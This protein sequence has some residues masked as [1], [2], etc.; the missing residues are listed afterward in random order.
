M[1]PMGALTAISRDIAVHIDLCGERVAGIQRRFE[2]HTLMPSEAKQELAEAEAALAA[3][4]AAFGIVE[5]HTLDACESELQASIADLHAAL[6]P[7][8]EP[9]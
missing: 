4:R 9:K 6:T 3:W 5:R 8:G 2:D 1:T 7:Q